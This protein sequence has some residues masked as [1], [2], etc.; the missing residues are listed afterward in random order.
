M[1][2]LRNQFD[3][4]KVEQKVEIGKFLAEIISISTT[5]KEIKQEMILNLL[6]TNN[7]D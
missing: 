5:R 3:K 7:S 4:L 2:D 1:N 6:I